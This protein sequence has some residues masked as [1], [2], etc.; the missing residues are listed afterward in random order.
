MAPAYE[1]QETGRWRLGIERV[2]DLDAQH[3]ARFDDSGELE[4]S[5]DYLRYA[6]TAGQGDRVMLVARDDSTSVMV[7]AL[8]AT[9]VKPGS[10]WLSRPAAVLGGQL[11]LEEAYQRA[12]YPAISVRN[13]SDSRPFIAAGMPPPAQA[14]IRRFLIDGLVGL[15]RE[16]GARSVT[17]LNVS[18]EDAALREE[19]A[20]RKFCPAMYT[21]DAVIDLGSAR[22]L[23]EYLG[24]LPKRR[25]VNARNEVSR[26]RRSGLVIEEGDADALPLVVG[27]EADTWAKYGDDV[28]FDALWRL[29]EPLARHL[30]G[31]FRLV[32]CK[33]PAGHVV[34]SAI[35]LVGRHCYH[36]FTYGARHPAPSGVYAMMTFYEPAR[37]AV[38]HGQS[39]LMLGDTTLRAKALRGAAIRP[40]H[41]YTLAFEEQGRLFYQQ[42]A[43]QLARRVEQ[44]ISQA[45]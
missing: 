9:M 36:C 43:G 37:Y 2:T 33:D 11:A 27:Q 8:A 14:A 6:D 26:F 32:L 44:E 24:T 18:A 19:L 23:D 30:V 16:S 40:L 34:A 20:D 3:W 22:T 39:R 29:R 4:F 5:L 41:A 12:L 38:E 1:H 35:H 17:F 21:A 28:G 10:F 25:R 31:R 15:A 45:A 7:G 42:L 13:I